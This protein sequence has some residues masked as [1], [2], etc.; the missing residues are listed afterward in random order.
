MYSPLRGEYMLGSK[1]VGL[2][3]PILV[4]QRGVAAPLHQLGS[5]YSGVKLAKHTQMC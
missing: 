1:P 5:N 4:K 3:N 2:Y